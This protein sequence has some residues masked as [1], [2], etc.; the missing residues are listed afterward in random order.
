MFKKSATVYDLVGKSKIYKTFW[1]PLTIGVMN[2]SPKRASATLLSNV[3]KQTIFR[4]K[5]V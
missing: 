2:T 1:E 5:N 3:L 4:T